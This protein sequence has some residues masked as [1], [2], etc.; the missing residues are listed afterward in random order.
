[1]GAVFDATALNITWPGAAS[2]DGAVF[3][4]YNDG[5]QTTRLSWCTVTYSVM[6]GALERA[7]NTKTG[8]YVNDHCQYVHVHNYWGIYSNAASD[9][10]TTCLNC[11]YKNLT[12]LFD[13]GGFGPI[14]FLEC[15]FEQIQYSRSQPGGTSMSNCITSTVI[16]TYDI[17]YGN[18]ACPVGT[19]WATRTQPQN[20]S[21]T[22]HATA[23][24]VASQSP[25]A[26]STISPTVSD[27]GGGG[28]FSGGS[29][30]FGSFASLPQEAGVGCLSVSSCTFLEMRKFG[31]ADEADGVLRGG[32]ISV[33]GL[34]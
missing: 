22:P 9:S 14:V 16:S 20:P 30:M 28:V 31:P 7:D 27:C 11:L 19:Q 32:A 33:N 8:P 21:E 29:Y 25:V 24:A 18:V 34:G 6:N 12:Y 15:Q 2:S 5:G 1:L 3:R 10:V 23:T 4:F 26:T 17:A 13:I